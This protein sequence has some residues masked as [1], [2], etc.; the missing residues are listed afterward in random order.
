MEIIFQSRLGAKSSSGIKEGIWA[1]ILQAEHLDS[2]TE[3][4]RGL[5]PDAMA[6]DTARGRHSVSESAPCCLQ[7]EGKSLQATE[8]VG[9]CK[10]G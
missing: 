7:H 1:L 6:C 9:L 2:V 4:I 3:G 5:R 10:V 8:Y